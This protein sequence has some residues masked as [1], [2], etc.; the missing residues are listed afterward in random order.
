MSREN[1]SASQ[2]VRW[3]SAFAIGSTALLVLRLWRGFFWSHALIVG[4]AVAALVYSAWG[5]WQR[6]RGGGG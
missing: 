3:L 4:L 2:A 1:L 5:T 6:M